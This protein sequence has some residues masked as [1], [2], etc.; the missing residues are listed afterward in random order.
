[1]ISYVPFGAWVNVERR[2]HSSSEQCQASPRQR[3]TGGVR[4]AIH[5][6]HAAQVAQPRMLALKTTLMGPRLPPLAVVDAGP[7]PH[8]VASHTVLSSP[9]RGL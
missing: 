4:G 1:M 5:Q 9:T 2:E 7:D 3:E 8:K 6:P